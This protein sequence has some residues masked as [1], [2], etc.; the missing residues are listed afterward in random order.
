[1]RAN[2]PAPIMDDDAALE[3][4]SN[5]RQW[6]RRVFT[7]ESKPY[8]TGDVRRPDVVIVNDPSQAPVQSNI[9]L[10]VEM[11]FPPDRYGP[12]QQRDYIK[13]A[14]SSEKVVDIG[15][16]D[17]GCPDE[18]KKKKTA[19]SSKAAPQTD[20]DDLFG[21]NGSST[22]APAMQPPPLPPIPAFP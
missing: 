19:S 10:V 4:H 13:I 17:C 11:K 7:D 12:G 2:P 8:K 22:G 16:A 9:K 6:V 1:M 14:G 3:P 20:L 18:D 21:G 5:I 15:P